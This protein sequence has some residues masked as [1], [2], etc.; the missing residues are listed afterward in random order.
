MGIPIILFI[1]I[2]YGIMEFIW[3]FFD[4][5]ESWWFTISQAWQESYEDKGL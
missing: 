1:S 3:G 5:I 4:S 2:L